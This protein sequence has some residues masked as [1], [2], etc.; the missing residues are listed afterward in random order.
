HAADDSILINYH[1]PRSKVM[2]VIRRAYPEV[3]PERVHVWTL[4]GSSREARLAGLWAEWRELGAHVVENDWALPGGGPMFTDSGTYAAVYSVGAHTDEAGQQ[5]LFL[6]DGYAA[7]AEAIQAAGLDPV[8]DS[9]TSLSLFSST[10]QLPSERER[11]V[12]RLDAEAE[13]FAEDLA[14]VAGEKPSDATVKAYRDSIEAAREAGMPCDRKALTIDDFFPRKQWRGL[15][16]DGFIQPDPYSSAA[17]VEALGDEAY[18]VT[19]RAAT[20]QG[21][22]QVALTLRLQET[23]D[24]SRLVFSPLLDRFYAG[25]D[26]R[27]RP[28]KVSDS[29]RLRNE[30]Q[31]LCSGGLDYLSDDRMCLHLDRIDDAVL[32]PDK[33]RL[34]REALGW[35]KEEHPIWFRWLEI[36][37]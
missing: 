19:V 4:G 10:F 20:S 15:T 5:H 2:E 34:I 17:G 30:L 26:Y 33:K 29:G 12:M 14:R 3:T 25:Q 23:F 18:R 32:A 21:L 24:E 31:T 37:E 7:S 9:A 22:R 1:T 8:L 27:T 6:C 28:V 36:A 16:L 13:S 11:D 35:Y